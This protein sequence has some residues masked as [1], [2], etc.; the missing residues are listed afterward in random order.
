[1]GRSIISFALFSSLSISSAH[2]S[3]W[4]CLW[5]EIQLQFLL[6]SVCHRKTW[7]HRI[8]GFNGNIWT[9]ARL[10]SLIF[11]HRRLINESSQGILKEQVESWRKDNSVISCSVR[12]EF[13]VVIALVFQFPSWQQ[14]IPTCSLTLTI[15]FLHFVAVWVT[16]PVVGFLSTKWTCWITAKGQPNCLIRK[17]VPL[18]LQFPSW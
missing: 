8:E 9:K 14:R 10:H 11:F 3:C 16:K 5:G 12:I 4:H 17:D 13:F 15:P 2:F 18:V 7:N 1:M 6:S